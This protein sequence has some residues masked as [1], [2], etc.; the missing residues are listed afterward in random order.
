MVTGRVD[1]PHASSELAELEDMLKSTDSTQPES[2]DF[3]VLNWF[4]H[5][6]SQQEKQGVVAQKTRVSPR[7]IRASHDRCPFRQAEK[8]LPSLPNA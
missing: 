5:L 3:L 7:K 1:S 6:L 2:Q 8:G 4:P